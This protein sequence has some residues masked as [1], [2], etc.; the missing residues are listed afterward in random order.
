MLLRYL[1]SPLRNGGTVT[2]YAQ[3]EKIAAD[4]VVEP[5]QMNINEVAQ[6]VLSSMG[7]GYSIFENDKN[8]NAEILECNK[9]YGMVNYV[10]FGKNVMSNEPH[11]NGYKS[12][13]VCFDVY[14]FD[15]NSQTYK[16][17]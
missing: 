3:W 15:M 11:F 12:I 10:S 9:Q 8:E 7:E 13:Y 16:D 17:I 14:E 5:L 1:S 2:L 4:P 6:S